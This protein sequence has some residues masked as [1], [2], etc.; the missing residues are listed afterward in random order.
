MITQQAE[1]IIMDRPEVSS[2][3]SGIGFVSGSVAGTSNDSNLAELTVTMTDVKE[4]SITS[5]D[6]GVFIQV[7]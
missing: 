4:R 1:K 7:K 6:F 3:F 2:V 5:E